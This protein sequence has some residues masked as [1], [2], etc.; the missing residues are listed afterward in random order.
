[1]LTGSSRY[2]ASADSKSTFPY[3]SDSVRFF[4]AKALFYGDTPVPSY[5]FIV[6]WSMAGIFSAALIFI[7]LCWLLTFVVE[8]YFYARKNPSRPRMEI[9]RRTALANVASYCFLIA[10]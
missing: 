6:G 7:G 3:L 10:L 9:F 2:L 4:L 5:G 8:G 1:V